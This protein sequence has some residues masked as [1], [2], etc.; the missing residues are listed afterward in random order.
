MS[1]SN[2][3]KNIAANVYSEAKSRIETFLKEH[4]VEGTGVFHTHTAYG[5][6]WGK[7][8]ISADEMEE[9]VDLYHRA[10]QAKV[11]LHITERP[12]QI[13]PLLID[14]DFN[15]NKKKTKDIIKRMILNI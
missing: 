11:D 7:F 10:L 15:F 3:G 5:A 1:S 8:N 13:G 9:F 2:G 6:P 14:I 12:T 4:K